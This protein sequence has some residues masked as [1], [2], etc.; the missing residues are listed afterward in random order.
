MDVDGDGGFLSFEKEEV[1]EITELVK[2]TS[3]LAS[4][5]AHAREHPSEEKR[6]DSPIDPT[7][8]VEPVFKVS[9]VIDSIMGALHG[10][11]LPMTGS[12][13][14]YELRITDEE[15]NVDEDFPE[16]DM[17]VHIGSVGATRFALCNAGSDEPVL[18]V[19]VPEALAG[20]P[21]KERNEVSDMELTCEYAGPKQAAFTVSLSSSLA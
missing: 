12:P 15:G 4:D 19:N 6:E 3:L 1:P 14:S 5:L 10:G 16:L 2:T 9:N 21:T 18:Y 11:S 20:L 13:P 7:A 17:G 8:G